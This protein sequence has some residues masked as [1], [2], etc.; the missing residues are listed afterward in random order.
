MIGQCYNMDVQAE[1]L[2]YY[3]D[4]TDDEGKARRQYLG[5]SLEKWRFALSCGCG[6]GHYYY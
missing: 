4:I 1:G 2:H 6:Q 5:K 3:I